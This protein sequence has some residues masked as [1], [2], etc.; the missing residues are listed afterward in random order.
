MLAVTR[1]QGPGVDFEER[2]ARVVDFWR[3][4]QGN[5]RVDLVQNLDDPELWAIVSEWDSVGSYRRSFQGYEAKMILT[6]VLLLAVDEPSAY[7]APD[8]L[9]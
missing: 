5:L 6:E 1:F 8:E 3:G 9:R 2:A 7:L 4:C